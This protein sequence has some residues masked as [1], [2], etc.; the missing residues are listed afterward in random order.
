MSIDYSI[1]AP[2]MVVYTNPNASLSG[3]DPDLQQDGT[4]ST[5]S[6]SGNS[7]RPA[8]I[9][10]PI[11]I[12]VNFCGPLQ[13]VLTMR[14]GQQQQQQQQQPAQGQGGQVQQS[15]APERIA[16]GWGTRHQSGHSHRVS[17]GQRLGPGS[18]GGSGNV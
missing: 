5:N 4:A 12:N 16:S 2:F 8:L 1:I 15:L 18:S 11:T 17:G 7:P 13:S 9:L 3:S 6:S 10:H 14:Q